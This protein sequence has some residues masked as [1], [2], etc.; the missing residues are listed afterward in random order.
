VKYKSF[1]DYYYEFDD[2]L[3]NKGQSI[4]II[5]FSVEGGANRKI[6][7]A[8][9]SDISITSEMEQARAHKNITLFMPPTK[10]HVDMEAAVELIG[11][12]LNKPADFGIDFW[13]EKR[14]GNNQLERL[15]LHEE[16]P[17]LIKRPTVIAGHLL[18]IEVSLPDAFLELGKWQKGKGWQL[19]E[20]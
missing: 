2:L 7:L 1:L 20:M 19:E 11:I 14:L 5:S 3:Y 6:Y 10:N 9:S 8:S 13:V 15:S 16:N 17:A 18:M 12:A 4:P